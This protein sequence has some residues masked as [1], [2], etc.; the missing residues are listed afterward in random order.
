MYT[1]IHT[2]ESLCLT[3]E[4]FSVGRGNPQVYISI[5]LRKKNRYIEY[6]TKP[7]CEYHFTRKK[8]DP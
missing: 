3:S 4:Q 1:H 5:Y 7:I 8:I 2:I 6:I